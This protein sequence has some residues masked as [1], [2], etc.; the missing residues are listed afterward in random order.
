VISGDDPGVRL[1]LQLLFW[2]AALFSFVMAVL[3]HPPHVP[4]N[5]KIQHMAAFGTLAV[6]G[7][8]A[9]P[10]HP[11]HRLLIGL[12]LFGALIEIVQAIPA[13]HRDSDPLDWL[14]DTIAVAIVL[15]AVRWWRSRAR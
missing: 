13:V 8:F 3:P 5:D 1:I 15:L 6:L 2:A 10:Q 4:A 7:S 14:A 11:F 9:Y 12:S